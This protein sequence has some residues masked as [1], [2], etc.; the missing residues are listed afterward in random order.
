MFIISINT[1][2]I[3]IYVCR[4]VELSTVMSINAMACMLYIWRSPF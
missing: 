2:Y 1:Y 4:D 3:H